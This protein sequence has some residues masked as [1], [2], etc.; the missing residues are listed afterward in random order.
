MLPGRVSFRGLLPISN[1]PGHMAAA[2]CLV[3]P[4]SHD[5]WGAVVR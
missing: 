3:L 2:D 5:G 1:I 4:S